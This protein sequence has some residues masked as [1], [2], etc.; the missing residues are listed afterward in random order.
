MF[1]HSG[2]LMLPRSFA[3]SYS[4]WQC[5]K[6]MGWRSCCIAGHGMSAGIA[7]FEATILYSFFC[8]TQ[9]GVEKRN[10]CCSQYTKIRL[11]FATQWRRHM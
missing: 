7:M 2:S 11:C 10:R 8:V 3:E 4:V 9:Y 5:S 6:V 1:I